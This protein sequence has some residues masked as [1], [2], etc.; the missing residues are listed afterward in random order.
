MWA[1]DRAEDAPVATRV[2]Q[3][4][5][6]T[7]AVTNP[8]STEQSIDF[9]QL[10]RGVVTLAA[11]KSATVVYRASKPGFFV[12]RGTAKANAD[13]VGVLVVEPRH[14][15]RTGRAAKEFVLV[16]SELSVT[17][18]DAPDLLVFNSYPDQYLDNPLTVA[19]RQRV[20]V[21]VVNAG[22]SGSAFAVANVRDVRAWSGGKLRRNVQQLRLGA[23]SGAV[24]AFTT[25]AGSLTYPF[26][27]WSLTDARLHAAGLLRAEAAP[28]AAPGAASLRVTAKDV[29]FEPKSL[30][31]KAGKT[32]VAI[33]NA[34]KLPHTFTIDGLANLRVAPGQSKSVT[35][36]LKAGTY[37]YYCAEPGHKQAGMV[38]TLK[39]T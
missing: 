30:T 10:G 27:G 19:P 3:G 8:S 2:V 26:H 38:G 13:V 39:V 4:A 16:Q 15:W 33:K 23:G 14:G 32:T 29:F 9:R 34:G 7:I 21:F 28:P 1:F 20:R 22:R 12:Y 5:K 31:A 37:T 24:L 25:R 35:L 11:G 36:D 18:K 6:V 17:G